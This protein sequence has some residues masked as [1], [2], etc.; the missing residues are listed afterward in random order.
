[1]LNRVLISKILKGSVCNG[2][3]GA[4]MAGIG[5]LC[6]GALMDHAKF[7]WG[8][9][10]LGGLF[11]MA[12]MPWFA[13][14]ST[15][16]GYLVGTFPL[17]GGLVIGSHALLQYHRKAMKKREWERMIQSSFHGKQ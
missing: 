10:S 13:C 3:L 4:P 17:A 12:V 5:L 8:D 6:T 2:W 14:A 15:A 16:T 1:M 7:G 11:G 9:T